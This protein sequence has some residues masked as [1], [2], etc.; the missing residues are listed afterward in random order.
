LTVSH[1]YSTS[2]LLID[3][4][5]ALSPTKRFD[6]L[7]N[8][9]IDLNSTKENVCPEVYPTYST[10]EPTQLAVDEDIGDYESSSIESVN[11]S[12]DVNE[13]LMTPKPHRKLIRVF[14]YSGF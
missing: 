8:S 6:K 10:E 14:F 7:L 9:A 13:F 1:R 11:S 2:F 5:D 3:L 12:I 4:P